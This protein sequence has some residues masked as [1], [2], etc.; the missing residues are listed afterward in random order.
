MSTREEVQPLQIRTVPFAVAGM[1]LWALGGLGV[2]VFDGPRH[3]IGIC[4]AGV[5]IGIPGLLT[6]IRH[7]RRER[8][9]AN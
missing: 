3:W 7:D 9:A 4:V 1:V 2:L 8:R 6:M 5:L